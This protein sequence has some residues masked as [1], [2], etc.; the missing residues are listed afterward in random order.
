MKITAMHWVAIT[1][2]LLITVTI[3]ATMNLAFNWIFYITMLGQASVVVMVYK[4]LK[5]NYVTD[6]T[7]KDRYEDFPQRGRS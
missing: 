4:V 1:T 5:D 6:K 7:F 3:F 2:L